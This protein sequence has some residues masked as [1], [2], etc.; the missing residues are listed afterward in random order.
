MK[1]AVPVKSNQQ[2]DD[3]FGHCEFYNIYSISEQNEI[4]DIQTIKSQQGCGCKSNIASTLAQSGVTIMLAG[5]IGNGAINVLENSGI[6]TIKGCSGDSK[7]LVSQYIKGTLID[8]GSSCQQ[9]KDHHSGES[10]HICNH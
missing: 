6:Q 3:H 7:D 9:H 10:V 2:I 1:I 5:G 4:T 8:S